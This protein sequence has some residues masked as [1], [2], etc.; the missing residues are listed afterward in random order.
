MADDGKVPSGWTIG[1]NKIVPLGTDSGSTGGSTGVTSGGSGGGASGGSTSAGDG[2]ATSFRYDGAGI[3]GSERVTFTGVDF[4]EGD[5]I[6]LKNF[7]AGTF[8]HYAGDNRMAIN[9]SQS[10]IQMNSLTDLQEVVTAS[11]DLT[12]LFRAGDTLVVRIAQDDGVLDIVLPGLA[13]DYQDSFD[14]S[15]F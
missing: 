5:R 1:N 9:D 13:D 15:L 14:S 6:T 7:D 4:G 11:K 12:A 2:T 10:Y 8:R 3:D